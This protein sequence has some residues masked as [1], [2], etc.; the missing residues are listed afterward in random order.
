[1][2]EELKKVANEL[3]DQV[4]IVK[5]DTDENPA[6]SSQLK[7]EGLPTL[8]FLSSNQDKPALRLEGMIPAADVIK[9]INE[10]L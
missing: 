8:L 1:M 6:L 4:K 5:V 3:K 7:I 9:I 2:A 10:E